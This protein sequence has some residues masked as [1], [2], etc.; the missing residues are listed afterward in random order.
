[1]TGVKFMS[2][3]CTPVTDSLTWCVCVIVEVEMFFKITCRDK[4]SR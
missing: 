4:M 2:N 3:R 1:M